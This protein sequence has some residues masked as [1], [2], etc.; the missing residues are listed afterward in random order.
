MP[1]MPRTSEKC[2]KIADRIQGKNKKRGTRK[3]SK[4]ETRIAHEETSRM[5]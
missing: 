3:K 1:V 2:Q 4:T 5:R